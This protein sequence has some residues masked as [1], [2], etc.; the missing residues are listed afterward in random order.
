MRNTVIPMRRSQRPR[1]LHSRGHLPSVAVL[2]SSTLRKEGDSF[3]ED[4]ALKRPSAMHVQLSKSGICIY[5]IIHDIIWPCM[6][7]MKGMRN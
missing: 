4:C 7:G 5:I 3:L 2:F 6:I 1:V